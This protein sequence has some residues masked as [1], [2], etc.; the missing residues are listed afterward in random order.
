MHAT[1]P[2][3]LFTGFLLLSA[4]LI[5]CV[6]A[7]ITPSPAP[8]SA[9]STTLENAPQFGEYFQGFTGT[10]VLHDLDNDRYLRYNPER[11]AQRFLPASTFK[12]VNSLIGLETG[13]IRDENQVLE[14]DGTQHE[15][16]TWNQNHTL[17]TAFRN[18]VVW[19]YQE[20]AR[21]VGR[22]QMKHYVDEVGYGNQDI[23]GNVDSFW[24]DGAI[25]ISA[26]EQVELLK[27]L[28]QGNLPFSRRSMKIVREIMIL[29]DAAQYRL[30][31]KTGSGKVGTTFIGWFV[32]Y[33][34]TMDNVYFVATNMESPGPEANGLKAK[35]ITHAIL[36]ELQL[37]PADSVLATPALSIELPY[38][39]TYND[40]DGS[41]KTLFE[42]PPAILEINGMKQ[43]SAVGTFCWDRGCS[44]PLALLTPR[45]ALVVT[46]PLVGSLM[47]LID[48]PP[49]ALRLNVSEASAED[50]M[51]ETGAGRRWWDINP[52][53]SGFTDLLLQ[54][55]Q[56]IGL[57]LESGLYVVSVFAA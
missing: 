35:E 45:E 18:S 6:G 56:P 12:I 3:R 7:S 47:L 52:N 31:G 21:R 32:G 24:L 48:H 34:E 40:P 4:L 55:E 33:V 44:D 41:V 29:D 15:I 46:S 17:K 37:L 19:Y 49:S 53:L 16:S 30:S 11:C 54:K 27:R 2:F 9:A 10:F 5:G 57:D 26:D 42:P 51:D 20:L 14:W 36:K 39:Y 23:T 50:E 8:T 25:R 1:E 22:E 43:V 38:T 28:Y 13:V